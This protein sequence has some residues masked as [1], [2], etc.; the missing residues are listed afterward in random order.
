MSPG[1]PR[2]VVAAV[3]SLFRHDDAAGPAAVDLARDRL[4]HAEV[5][6]TLATPLELM[7]AWDGA[8]LAVVVDA[9][10][11]GGAGA[12]HVV[13]LGPDGPPA[14]AAA[15]APRSSSHGIGVVE[16]LRLSRVCGTAPQRVVLVGVTGTEFGP[17]VGLSPQVARAVARAA[18]LVVAAVAGTIGPGRPGTDAAHCR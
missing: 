1:S 16:V 9:L 15:P 6:G 8:D 4:G 13:E 7:G 5:L 12:V 17:G 2:V 10:R 14:G 18:D 11:S 3:G